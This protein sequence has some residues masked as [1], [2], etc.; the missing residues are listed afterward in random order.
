MAVIPSLTTTPPCCP[1]Q[2]ARVLRTKFYCSVQ[3]ALSIVLKSVASKRG[4][5][6]HCHTSM[7]EGVHACLGR[8][9]MTV[10][11]LQA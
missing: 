4:R 8:N 9:L 7:C 5:M 3:S 1:E 11:T 2:T 6:P 10:R